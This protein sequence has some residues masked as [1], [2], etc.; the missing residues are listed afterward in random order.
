MSLI[1]DEKERAVNSALSFFDSRFCNKSLVNTKNLDSQKDSF[2]DDQVGR[3]NVLLVDRAKKIPEI[4]SICF[5]EVVP[6]PVLKRDGHGKAIRC[7]DSELIYPFASTKL[8]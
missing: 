7:S 5:S 1:G 6:M 8:Q 2:A 3:T 4:A